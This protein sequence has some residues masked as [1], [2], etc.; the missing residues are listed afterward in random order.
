MSVNKGKLA[1][2]WW[3]MA[4]NINQDY[5]EFFLI[6]S[7]AAGLETSEGRP[8]GVGKSSLSIWTAY[9]A[10]AYDNGT[11][12][13]D[14]DQMIDG[15]SKKERIELMKIIVNRY[16][17]WSLKGIIEIIK[18]A[19]GTIPAIIWDD[20]QRDCP[21]YQHVPKD[22]REMIEYLTM[23]RQRVANLVLTA[24][25]M[26]DIAKPL[27]RN[28]SWEIIVPTRGVY[29]VHFIGKRRDFYNPTE[30]KSRLWYDVT[31][32]FEALPKE[33][34]ILYKRRRDEQLDK[35]G[36]D[37]C[38]VDEVTRNRVIELYNQ[39]TPLGRIAAKTNTP[40]KLVEKIV[41]YSPI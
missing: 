6:T 24:P 9:R 20:V 41:L 15:T 36:E 26:G 23:T 35:V 8:F 21:A 31:G 25:S 37:E 12:Y 22:K 40:K 11:L 17:T 19:D 30:D 18:K 38:Y 33:I 14:N 1:S 13:F 2:I 7:R 4:Q 29:E 28:I 3:R 39:G 27:R 32:T 5:L 10:F 16:I 34:D